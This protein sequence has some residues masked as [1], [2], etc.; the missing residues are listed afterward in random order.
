MQLLK[1]LKLHFDDSRRLMPAKSFGVA[2]SGK[3][4]HTKCKNF[5][6]FPSRNFLAVVST[7]K[8]VS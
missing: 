6:D 3:F 1:I 5:A 8:V 4:M 7:L 2:D